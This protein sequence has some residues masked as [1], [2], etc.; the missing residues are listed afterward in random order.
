MP[1]RVGPH[2][3]Q[4]RGDRP[5]RIA[6]DLIDAELGVGARLDEPG[7]GEHLELERDRAEGDIR[8]GLVNGAGRQLLFPQQPQNLA[9]PGRPDS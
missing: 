7:V 9:A 3:F 4:H 2:L 6:A 8:H 5:K 1:Q